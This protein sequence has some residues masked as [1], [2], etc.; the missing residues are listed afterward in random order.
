MTVKF[1]L[2]E[3]ESAPR[4]FKY[5]KDNKQELIWSTFFLQADI[6]W[7]FHPSSYFV[8]GDSVENVRNQ[9]CRNSSHPSLSSIAN[10]SNDHAKLGFVRFFKY[11]FA[12]WLRDR[13]LPS[14]MLLRQIWI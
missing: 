1:V 12:I 4:K 7:L 10:K 14:Y 2:N 6:R 3:S 11:L 9:F 5:T 8:Q 13:H